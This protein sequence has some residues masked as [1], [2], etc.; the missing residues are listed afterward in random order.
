M[1]KYNATQ[2]FIVAFDAAQLPSPS[3]SSDSNATND[4]KERLL[5]ILL[6]KVIKYNNVRAFNHLLKQCINGILPLSMDYK[7]KDK[8][9][10]YIFKHGNVDMFNAYRQMYNH[11]IM[12]TKRCGKSYLSHLMPAI[13]T[14]NVHVSMLK[15]LHDEYDLLYN[16]NRGEGIID[17]WMILLMHSIK[18]NQ[19][20][21]VRYIMEHIASSPSAHQVHSSHLK[22]SLSRCSDSIG[23]NGNVDILDALCSHPKCLSVL[24]KKDYDII[25]LLNRAADH[26]HAE[27]IKHIYSTYSQH[28]D[29]CPDVKPVIHSMFEDGETM[30]RLRVTPDAA[31][32]SDDLD[33]TETLID[34]ICPMMNTMMWSFL[35]ERMAMYLTKARH[36][37][38]RFNQLQLVELIRAMDM[39]GSSITEAII[40]RFIDNCIIERS[41][42]YSHADADG[43][44]DNDHLDDI[45]CALRQATSVSPSLVQHI[46]VAFKLKPR[47][48]YKLSLN[49]EVLLLALKMAN[50]DQLS[51]AFQL[52]DR[53][54]IGILMSDEC[55]KK[56]ILKLA[57]KLISSGSLDVVTLILNKLPWI[58]LDPVICH[59]AT[60][61]YNTDV[62]HYVLRLFPKGELGVNIIFY[63]LSC[64]AYVKDTAHLIVPILNQMAKSWQLTISNETLQKSATNNAYHSLDY[65]F[66]TPMFNELSKS[67]TLHSILIHAYELGYTTIVKKCNAMINDIQ[68]IKKRTHDE[69]D[70]FENV[71]GHLDEVQHVHNKKFD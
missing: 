20:D 57:K 61:N 24:F 12:S 19:T 16:D 18:S 15:M 1:L 13:N 53:D 26:R 55:T 56:S 50:F 10:S 59:W 44:D 22:R 36:P 62:F 34:M 29:R 46:C 47:P 21:S 69:M 8:M 71:I 11:H 64:R 43:D 7:S 25:S 2:M 3:P 63:N 41:Q 6:Y 5:S 38:L 65:H 32:L 40:H 23:K 70:I 48:D 27:L 28:I 42:Y 39:P 49:T 67:S 68:S 60:S 58:K 33:A 17:L 54:M 66:G 51:I 35:S 37:S 9:V 52:I 14:G 30:S 31:I 45:Y 4:L